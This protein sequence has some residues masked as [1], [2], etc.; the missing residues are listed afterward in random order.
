MAESSRSIRQA[1]RV[2]LA[3]E[4]VEL[5]VT[6]FH[7]AVQVRGTDALLSFSKS[8]M[9]KYSVPPASVDSTQS[10]EDNLRQEV[11][12]LRQR[13]AELEHQLASLQ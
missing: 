2:R 1:L 9:Q 10:S 13:C 12:H 5:F 8:L 11:Q 6:G 7:V 3:N 4:K